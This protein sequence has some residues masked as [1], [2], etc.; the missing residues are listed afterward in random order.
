MRRW[1]TLAAVSCLA[2]AACS[3]GA[4]Q[5]TPPASSA[6]GGP[7]LAVTST[8]SGQLRGRNGRIAFFRY[9]SPADNGSMTINADGTA[10][11]ALFAA[12]DTEHPHWSPDGTEVAMEC[13]S[14]DGT[15]LIVNPDTGAFRVLP[16]Y[17]GL[18]TL[19]C[20]A[21]WSPDGSRI[22]CG[23]DTDNTDPSLWGVYTVR[24]S[25]GGGL[26]KVTSISGIPGDYSPDGKR[27]SFHSADIGG[28]Q[29]IYVVELTGRGLTPITPS[30]MDIGD[31]YGGSW[32][33]TG[34][35]IL[36]YG[37]SAPDQRFTLWVLNPGSGLQQLAIPSC[38]GA[39]ADPTSHGCY[40]PAWSPDGTK[41]ALVRNSEDGTVS[42]IY[43]VNAD[44]SGLF[45]VT[46]DGYPYGGLDWGPPPP[47]A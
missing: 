14:C 16:G 8:P 4:G 30:G 17:P 29:R 20:F 25:D 12:A 13:D 26:T 44:G 41:I 47:P 39:I 19:G 42:D 34:D 40:D 23:I 38:G 9:S 22:A 24:S 37:R 3:S 2:L 21:A 33:P 7:S 31:E 43:T 15:A 10:E 45:Q 11:K 6:S 35:K 27:L 36:F 28:V 32:S 5:A 46:H 1:M 18:D